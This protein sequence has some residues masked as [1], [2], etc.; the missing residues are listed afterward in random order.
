[1]RRM[2]P[3]VSPLWVQFWEHLFSRISSC[4]LCVLFR[5]SGRSVANNI[6]AVLTVLLGWSSSSNVVNDI[7]GES[8]WKGRSSTSQSPIST[9]SSMRAGGW[10]RSNVC[11]IYMEDDVYG[12]K[13]DIEPCSNTLELCGQRTWKTGQNSAAV[14]EVVVHLE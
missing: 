8:S 9:F 7:G 2:G 1:M 11:M 13:G 12:W 14:R 4:S 3:E 6:N 5:S 10:V